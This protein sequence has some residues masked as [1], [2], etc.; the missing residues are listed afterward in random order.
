MEVL[1]C[2]RSGERIGSGFPGSGMLQKWRRMEVLQWDECK[3]D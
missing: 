3:I 1:G 2:Q